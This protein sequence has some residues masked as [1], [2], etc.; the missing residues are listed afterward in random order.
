MKQKIVSYII[1]LLIGLFL[2]YL[3]FGSDSDSISNQKEDK[4]ANTG[5]WTCSMHPKVQNESE[6]KCPLCAMDLVYVSN[7]NAD[8]S[9]SQF[10][11]SEDA[12]TLASIE[13][14]TIGSGINENSSTTL[15]GKIITNTKTDGIQTSIF[16]G[17]I[18]KL[19]TNYVGKKVYKG[20]KIGIIYSPELI[21]AQDEFLN[22]VKYRKTHERL[23]IAARNSDGLWKVPDVL[24]DS[25]ISTGKTIDTFPI[26]ADVS[27]TITDVIAREGDF[28]KEGDAIFKTSDLRKVWAV[29][30]CYENQLNG[31]KKGDDIEVLVRGASQKLIKAK[32]DF[33]EPIMD[34][35][36]RTVNIRVV[37]DN[38]EG[39]LKPGMFVTAQLGSRV[40]SSNIVNIPKS[41]VLWTGTRSVVYLKPFKDKSIFEM[42]EVKLGKRIGDYYEVLDGVSEGDMIVTNG[43]FTVDATAELGGK[44]SMMSM[45]ENEPMMNHHNDEK[46]L[47][48]KT[49][50]FHLSAHSE[51]SFK[52]LLKYYIDLKDALIK[53]DFSETG[54]KAKVFEDEI[55]KLLKSTTNDGKEFHVI[56]KNL[57]N[58][59]NAK[60]LKSQRKAFKP[61]SDYLI[62]IFSQIKNLESKVFVQHCDCVDDFTGGSWLSLDSKVLN[63][64]F[65]D[66]MLNCGRV[67]HTFN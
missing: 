60:T 9:E 28:Y 11:M 18:E 53:S 22:S 21:P 14:F 62:S 35:L 56:Q 64:Y 7:Q 16:N 67:E 17:R 38:K 65:G 37:L 12:I 36:S 45:S 33:I 48:G 1:I 5:S 32:I 66:T 4:T 55:K 63:P 20:Q 52:T 42:T 29:F 25:I 10:E 44:K 23:F 47:K 49:V 51:D 40:S 39:T 31:L 26:Y 2:G 8:L 15:S 34:E 61:L 58:I 19:Y 30:D 57:N 3:F 59:S 27:G 43:A 50:K 13:T 24:I 46:D 54:N 6:G 41:A